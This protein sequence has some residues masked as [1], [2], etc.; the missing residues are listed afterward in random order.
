MSSSARRS[1]ACG[2][3]ERESV[4][5]ACPAVVASQV[6]AVEAERRHH[7]DLILRHHALGVV[8]VALAAVP[9]EPDQRSIVI[10]WKVANTKINPALV[11]V[12]ATVLAS[13]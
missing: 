13:K 4:R 8:S 2:W 7:L 11:D 6:E 9:A 5:D 12:T 10:A 3:S 1:T